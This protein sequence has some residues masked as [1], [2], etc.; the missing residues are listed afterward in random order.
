MEGTLVVFT[1]RK[2]MS[3]AEKVRFCQQF[4]G[5]DTTTWKG[6]YTYHMSGF[7]GSI[8][9]RKLGKGIIIIRSIDL[10][11]VK[12]YFGDKVEEVYIR[13]VVLEEEDV[14]ILEEVE[15]PDKGS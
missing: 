11:K 6:K 13:T 3:S 1:L 5:R 15:S 14:R 9:H 7:L 10:E 12:E 4:Y 8:P 2:N